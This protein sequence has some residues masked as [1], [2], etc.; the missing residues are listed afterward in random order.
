MQLFQECVSDWCLQ[1]NTTEQYTKCRSASED[2]TI[3]FNPEIR[4]GS[5]VGGRPTNSNS[6]NNILQ[7][8]QQLFPTSTHGD[9]T[10]SSSSSLN[11]GKGPLFWYTG[12]DESGYKWCDWTDGKWKD[13][14]LDATLTSSCNKRTLNGCIMTSVTCQ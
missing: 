2:G 11:V 9:A 12:Y 1:D 14:T 4:Y 10:Y 6:D 8:C 5:T 13:S 3:C 7:W